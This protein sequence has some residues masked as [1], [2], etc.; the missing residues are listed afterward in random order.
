[1]TCRLYIDEVGND[2]T[3]TE[4]ERYLSLTGIITKVG[5]HDNSITPAIEALKTDLFGHAPPNKVVI[6]HR[7]EMVRKEPPFKQLMDATVN[8]EWERR[9]LKLIEDLPYIANTVMIDKHEHRDRYKVWFLIE[10]YVLWL[11][12]HHLTGDVVAEPRYKQQDKRLKKSFYHIYD[13]GTGNIS[14]SIIRAH[15][16]SREIKFEP[17]E[18]NICGLQLVEMIANPS[19]QA[20]KSLFTGVPMTASFGKR[21]VDILVQSRYSRHPKT[22]RIEG[23]GQKRLP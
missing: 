17:K 3:E 13:H 11:R 4:S 10:R 14:G 23:W 18:A 21:V 1:M 5:S 22:G 8:A 12:R 20:I 19:H 16:T 15:L 9:I 2:D 7:R 6:L